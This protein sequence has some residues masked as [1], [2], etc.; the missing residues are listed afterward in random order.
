MTVADPNGHVVR[1]LLSN[2]AQ[3]AG[4]QAL[5]WDGRTQ[6][7]QLVATE[8]DYTVTLTATDP[9]SGLHFTRVGTVVV[10]K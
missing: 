9:V 3:T 6:T 10:Y 4:P 8:G 7:G 1:T 5:E 2:A